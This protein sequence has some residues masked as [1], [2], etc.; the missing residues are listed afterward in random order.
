MVSLLTHTPDNQPQIGYIWH[1]FQQGPS[2]NTKNALSTFFAVKI[3]DHG[4]LIF[5]LKVITMVEKCMADTIRILF[6]IEL[7]H[8]FWKIINCMKSV[9]RLLTGLSTTTT[10]LYYSCS[11]C[12]SDSRIMRGDFIHNTV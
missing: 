1:N 4:T 7:N 5:G 3:F 6:Y 10:N 8:S 12:K 11:K 9:V 2:Y